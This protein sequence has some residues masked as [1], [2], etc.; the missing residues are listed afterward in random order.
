M[1]II[2]GFLDFITD[3]STIFANR[4]GGKNV[5]ILFNLLVMI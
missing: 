4:V 2:S 3:F 5:E 1:I